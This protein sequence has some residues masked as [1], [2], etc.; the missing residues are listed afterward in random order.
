M[1]SYLLRIS[2][3]WWR[4]WSGK[5][6]AA[7]YGKTQLESSEQSDLCSRIRTGMMAGLATLTSRVG[8][9][10]NRDGRRLSTPQ[11]HHDLFV[12]ARQNYLAVLDSLDH[13]L[14]NLCTDL[15]AELLTFLHRFAI[16]DGKMRAAIDRD[17]ANDECSA[18][19]F[20]LFCS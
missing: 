8:S 4:R 14:V 12:V 7:F 1:I 18:P 20:A 5:E 3:H 10:A 6:V 16:D 2:R 11:R 19:N 15:E 13:D 17:R 9:T